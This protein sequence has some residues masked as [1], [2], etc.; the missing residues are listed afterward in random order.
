MVL[1]AW[2]PFACILRMIWEGGKQG[3]AMFF[4]SYQQASRMLHDTDEMPSVAKLRMIW[5]LCCV[6]LLNLPGR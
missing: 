5:F 6:Y 1:H 2:L 3:Q 4:L